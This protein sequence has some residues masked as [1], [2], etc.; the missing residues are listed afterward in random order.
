MANPSLKDPRLF[1]TWPESI[2]LARFQATTK[3]ATQDQARPTETCPDAQSEWNLLGAA[4]V[5]RV[6]SVVLI[7]SSA[8]TIGV[9][10]FPI[11]YQVEHRFFVR[12]MSQLLLLQI[13]F[14]IN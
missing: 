3:N 4:V 10:S 14:R 6:A 2:V 5:G 11:F 1:C 7:V 12:W 13:F 9:R 8:L